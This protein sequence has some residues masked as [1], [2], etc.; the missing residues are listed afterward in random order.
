[1]AEII[2]TYNEL[3]TFSTFE[4]RFEYLRLRGDV[5]KETFGVNRYINQL[6]YHSYEWQQIRYK[7]IAR[8]L[9]NDLGV[10]GYDIP[11]GVKIYVHHMN[12]ITV[13]D[14][15]NRSEFVFDLK[16][17]ISTTRETH[18]AIHY[19]KNKIYRIE[20]IE[21]YKNDTCPWK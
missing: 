21:R 5:G 6:L 20:P 17:L 10:E 11:D 9:G 13:E 1:M 8:D 18:D 12:P 7:V 14:I 19:N 15:L 3:I 2:R 16:Y 4:E